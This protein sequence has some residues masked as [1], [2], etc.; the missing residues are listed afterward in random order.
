MI[1]IPGWKSISVLNVILDFNGTI[2]VDGKLKST[3]KP[4]II[5]LA[6]RFHIYVITSDT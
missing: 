3:V 6:K 4:L 2:A 5:Q 1:E